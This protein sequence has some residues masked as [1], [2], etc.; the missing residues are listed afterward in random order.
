MS[1]ATHNPSPTPVR[2]VRGFVSY[3]LSRAALAL[4]LCWAILPESLLPDFFP[5][6]YWA[7][8][9]PIY[10]ATSFAACVLVGYPC[11]GLCATPTLDDVRN[12]VDEH[13]LFFDEV[14]K[15]EIGP[16]GDG[17]KKKK[18]PVKVGDMSLA[19]QLKAILVQESLQ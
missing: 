7:V 16:G 11:L 1:S 17:G 19:R 14:D 8:A 18:G 10:A 6:R 12:A 2:A 9:I 5:Q 3:L 15:E 13:S 4:Y